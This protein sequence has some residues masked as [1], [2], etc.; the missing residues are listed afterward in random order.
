MNWDSLPKEI[1]E[2]IMF[3]RKQL[4]CGDTKNIIKIQSLWRH[5]KTKILIDR[6][7]M[8]KYIKDFRIWNPNINEFII[9]SK[10]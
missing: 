5:Y 2:L 7:K 4:T 6:F 9:R 8:L 1:I 3:Y 10:L